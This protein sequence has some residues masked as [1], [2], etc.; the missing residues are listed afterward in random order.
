[1]AFLRSKQT[2]DTLDTGTPVA[3]Q[4]SVDGVDGRKGRPTPKRKEAEAANKRPLVA[5]SSRRGTAARAGGG[6]AKEARAR[7][8]EVRSREY[9]AMKAGDERYLPAKDKGPERR[10]VRDWVD[11]R[12]NIAEFFLPL[13]L[14]FFVAMIVTSRSAD[15]ASFVVLVAL[16]LLVLIAVV[17]AFIMWHGLKKRLR[18]KFGAVPKGTAMYAVMR[19]FQIRRARMP[20]PSSRSHGPRPE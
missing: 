6:T 18:A 10:F 13:A 20:K 11:A 9:Q 19:A 1:V 5:S 16:Y 8:R 14:V 17:D 15:V 7:Q 2:D 12:W 4:P 3:E